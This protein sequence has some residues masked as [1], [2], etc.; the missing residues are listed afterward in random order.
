MLIRAMTPADMTLVLNWAAA[1]GWNPA[2][3]RRVAKSIA[4]NTSWIAPTIPVAADPSP[5][6]GTPAV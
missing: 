2:D 5:F 4:V 3:W 6:H 1:E